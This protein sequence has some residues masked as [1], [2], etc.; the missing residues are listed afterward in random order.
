MTIPARAAAD[1]CTKLFSR[2]SV[3]FF[4]DQ[5]LTVTVREEI[6]SASWNYS[7]EGWS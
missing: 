5:S 6:D 2:P 4:C 7:E 3:E 1:K